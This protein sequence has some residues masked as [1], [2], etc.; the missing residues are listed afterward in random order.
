MQV[1]ATSAPIA[2]LNTAQP[3]TQHP[4]SKH[5][6]SGAKVH[7]NH[8]AENDHDTDD[9]KAVAPQT[10]LLQ[11]NP[12]VNSNGQTVGTRVNTTA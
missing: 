5:P 3:A 4:T 6:Q 12:T 8:D 1:S 9:K 7:E 11:I 2:G 10:T